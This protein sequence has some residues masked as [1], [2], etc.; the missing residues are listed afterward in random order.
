[1]ENSHSLLV[2]FC[3]I[4]V[5]RCLF[6]PQSYLFLGKWQAC[7]W[8]VFTVSCL[9]PTAQQVTLSIT[10]CQWVSKVTLT[11]F[12]NI[13]SKPRVIWTLR[14]LIRMMRTNDLANNFKNV[15]NVWQFLIFRKFLSFWTFLTIFDHF[16]IFDNFG[17]DNDKIFGKTHSKSDPWYLWPFRRL[18][19]MIRRQDLTNIK[20]MTKTKTM[21]A[22]KRMWNLWPLRHWQLR[23][24]IDDNLCDLTINCDTAVHWTTFAILAIFFMI[25]V[26][27]CIAM[28]AR[29]S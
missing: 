14:H 16:T 11:W 7:R 2:L 6:S 9:Q 19:L 22:T 29:K 3:I 24:W 5:P 15:D 26:C 20:I 13:K 18:F 27:W 12:W 1:M 8:V 21:T 28:Y 10:H 4:I 17:Q 23:T 25:V